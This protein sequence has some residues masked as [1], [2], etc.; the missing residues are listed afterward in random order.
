MPL[1]RL[2]DMLD[3]AR[4]VALA[5]EG[6]L[7]AMGTD[8]NTAMVTGRR[9]LHFNSLEDISADVEKL[10]RAKEI[11]TLGNWSAGQVLKHLAITMNG[12]VDGFKAMMPGPVRFLI[13]LFF[14][15]RFLT[16]TMPPGFKMS[17]KIAAE[18]LPGPVSLEEGLESFRQA[19]RRLQTEEKRAGH[20]ALGP[21]TRDEWVQMHCRHSELHLSFL[22]PVT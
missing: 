12:S 15:R 6:S 10:A 14:K 1:A 9:T 13:R 18:L 3:T 4:H 19:M 7:Q 2:P 11:Q 21:L 16:K 17:A 8:I 20:I 22:I 5:P